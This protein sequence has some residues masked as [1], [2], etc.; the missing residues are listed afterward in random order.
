MTCATELFKIDANEQLIY[1]Q[2]CHHSDA[3]RAY[4]QLSDAHFHRISEILQ[5]PP[6]KLVN[7]GDGNGFR[8][9]KQMSQFM[10]KCTPLT[11]ICRLLLEHI[12]AFYGNF[13]FSSEK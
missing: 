12:S 2:T 3:V 13:N 1:L 6:P 8:K 7:V 9:K 10:G 4:K 11:P 5:P